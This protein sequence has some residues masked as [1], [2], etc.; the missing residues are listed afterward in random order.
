MSINDEENIE[1]RK[2]ALRNSLL[3]INEIS[4]MADR[5][6]VTV[7]SDILNIEIKIGHYPSPFKNRDLAIMVMESII[8]GLV[9]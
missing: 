2:S 3:V 6:L 1:Q 5:S 7:R 9:K 4:I 8:E